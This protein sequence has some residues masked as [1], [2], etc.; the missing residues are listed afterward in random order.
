M[1]SERETGPGH[2]IECQTLDPSSPGWQSTRV[3]VLVPT[4]E[5]GM[6]VSSFLKKLTQYCEALINIYNA[7]SGGN[8]IAR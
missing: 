4:K 2:L 7:S 1:A 3:V 6:Q 5:L 8:S